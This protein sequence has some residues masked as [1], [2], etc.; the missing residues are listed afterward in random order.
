MVFLNLGS[1]QE[2]NREDAGIYFDDKFQDGSLEKQSSE[3]RIDQSP[4]N[5]YAKNNV[6]LNLKIMVAIIILL[7]FKE[8]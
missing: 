8:I 7:Y 5:L 6:L 2:D 3:K 4:P 1:Y